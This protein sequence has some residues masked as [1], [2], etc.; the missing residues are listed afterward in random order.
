[1]NESIDVRLTPISSPISQALLFE[2]TQKEFGESKKALIENR[3]DL[4][5]IRSHDT[6]IGYALFELVDGDKLVLD[7]I[8]FRSVI[9][10]HTLGEYCLCRLLKR[11]LKNSSY[12][13]FLLAS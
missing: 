4:L 2:S 3:G 9:K 6:V 13:Q 10:N 7:S 1:M 12:N 11:R 8:H 5:I